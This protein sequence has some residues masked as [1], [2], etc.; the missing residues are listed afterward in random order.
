MDM[1][2]SSLQEIARGQNAKRVSHLRHIRCSIN[3]HVR[4]FLHICTHILRCAHAY[5]A[6]P[7]RIMQRR[8]LISHRH[9][10]FEVLA[11]HHCPHAGASCRTMLVIHNGCHQC[12]IL[13]C[14]SDTCD[15]GFI[16]CFCLEDIRCLVSILAPHMRRGLNFDLVFVHQNIDWL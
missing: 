16:G 10:G 15:S 6:H 3:A 4:T 11:A 9:H 8:V 7:F 14:G 12:K 2:K 5:L 1:L 13:A